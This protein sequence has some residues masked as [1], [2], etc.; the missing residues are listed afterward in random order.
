MRSIPGGRFN[1][2][3][4]LRVQIWTNL[5][6]RAWER[7]TYLSLV[8]SELWGP[9]LSHVSMREGHGLE[10]SQGLPGGGIWVQ[11]ER[12]RE[13]RRVM[14]DTGCAD[15]PGAG[16]DTVGLKR[17]SDTLTRAHVVS[18]A[19]LLTAP[20]DDKDKSHSPSDKKCQAPG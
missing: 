1:T 5:A 9:N 11:D 20:A 17:P 14:A 2:G 3:D 6:S 13:E 12:V 18:L 4:S 16:P 15:D 8:A 7:T 19:G 10:T